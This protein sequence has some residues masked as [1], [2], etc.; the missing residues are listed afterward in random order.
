MSYND[1]IELYEKIEKER[2]RPLISYVTSSRANA[3]AQ[4]SS[5][6]IPEFARQINEIKGETNEIDILIISRGGD[7]VVPWRIISILR[8][9]F[10]NIGA[11]LPYE[12][13]SAATLLA[14]GAD[15]ILM[16]PFSNL[17]PVD[18]QLTSIR[19]MPGGQ[20]EAIR[21]GSEDLRHYLD[22]IRSD[23]GIS[24]QE[25]M[26][27][28]FEFI[29]KDVGAIPI[30]I[31][32][33]SSYLALSMG[34]KLLSLHMEDSSQ[35]KTIAEALNKSFFHHGYPLGRKEAKEIGLKVIDPHK[36]LEILMWQVWENVEE[37]MKCNKPFNPLEIVLSNPTTSNLIGPVP[38]AQIPSNL[39]PQVMQQAIQNILQQVNVVQIPPVDYELFQATL[40][41][42]R[43]K[44]E[45]KTKGKI[46][47]TRKPD[48][49]IAINTLKTFQGWTFSKSKGD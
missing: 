14:L 46:T 44:S 10:E 23:V 34:E 16:H 48:M 49:N 5:D 21:F 19:S 26:E 29:C 8:E 39:P 32:K 37:E 9:K 35:A 41:S 38:Q 33:K 40:E 43:C 4:M 17:G 22:F 13:Y 42:T 12:A 47:A 31:A 24:D 3:S 1:R 36:K 15:E 11:L 2:K 30:G 27:K 18:P 20:K 45:F 6:V 28:A 7:A 25:Q